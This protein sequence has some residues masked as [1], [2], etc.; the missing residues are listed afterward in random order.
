MDRFNCFIKTILLLLLLAG[1]ARNQKKS[2]PEPQLPNIIF[3]LAD[4]LGYGDISSFNPEGKIS[5]PNIDQLAKAGMLFTDAHT[6]SAVCTP[7]RYGIL[8]G[9]YNWR[10]G[11]KSGV[12]TG[13]SRALIPKSRSTVASL[14]KQAGY[15]TAFIGKWHLGWDWTLKDNSD[16]GGEGWD[17]NDFNVIDFTGPVSNT[18]NDLGFDYAY[19]HSGSLDMAPYVYVENGQITAT[20]D[21]ITENTDKY[22]W[23]RKGPTAAD[24]QHEEVT[25]N[26]FGKSLDYIQEKAT[27]ASPF[28]LYLALPSPHTP[29]L[30]SEEWQGKSGLNP[31]ADFVMMIDHYIGQLVA[32][33]KTA[34]IE[35]NTLLIFT[36]DN[37]CSPEAD[38]E[39]L[40]AKDHH[41][42]YIYRGHKADIFE[43]GHRVPFVAKWPSRIPAG[44]VNNSTICTTDFYAT[45]AD[46]ATI[47]M[48]DNS[49]E[50]SFSI[51]PLLPGKDM[52]G[53]GRE[54]TVHHSINGSF[55]IRKGKWKLIFAPDSGGWSPPRPGSAEAAQLP[56]I[57][58]YDLVKDPA[59]TQNIYK[60]HPMVVTELKEIMTRYVSEGRSR[61]GVKQTND[62]PIF[63]EQDWP[64]IEIFNN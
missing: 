57:Q 58:L 9:R 3:V 12:L 29:I 44:T 50:D 36:S 14:L 56:E 45:C 60:A 4:D 34:G 63:G 55:A 52:D 15:H 5:T 35:E 8:T 30:P 11:L 59:E 39:L 47:H 46:I 54:A 64:Q 49:G 20:V 42:S 22:S 28:F 51:L 31:Y 18:P 16:F 38:F 21:H 1:C 23:W 7:T 27:E 2:I 37:G 17:H 41:P 6:S 25:P 62:T 53:Y 33:T 10:S 32:L 24:F 48:T 61:P 40:A 13:K 19:G 43:G 26:F